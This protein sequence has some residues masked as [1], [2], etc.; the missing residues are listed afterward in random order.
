MPFW[1][2]LLRFAHQRNY[3]FRHFFYGLIKWPKS[4]DLATSYSYNSVSSQSVSQSVSQSISQSVSEEQKEDEEKKKGGHRLTKS[5]RGPTIRR[6]G[7][8]TTTEMQANAIFN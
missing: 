8:N 2:S 5:K 3:I 7:K 6:G 1:D 4:I